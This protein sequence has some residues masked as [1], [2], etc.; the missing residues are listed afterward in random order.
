MWLFFTTALPVLTDTHTLL[1][2]MYNQIPDV[3]NLGSNMLRAKQMKQTWLQNKKNVAQ[4]N[5]IIIPKQKS[6]RTSNT[7]LFN[8]PDSL[9][10]KRL[11]SKAECFI[12]KICT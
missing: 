3:N 4:C 9:T 10:Q 7:L 5:Q 12:N 2:K 1:L 6:E 8:E 11:Y